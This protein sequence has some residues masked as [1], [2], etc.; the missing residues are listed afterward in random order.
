[1]PDSCHIP[2]HVHFFRTSSHSVVKQAAAGNQDN[3]GLTERFI[4][5]ESVP[6]QLAQCWFPVLAISYANI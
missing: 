6:I 5:N 1:M 4:G 3:L 2:G